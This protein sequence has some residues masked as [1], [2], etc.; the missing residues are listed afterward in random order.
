MVGEKGDEGPPGPPGPKG[1]RGMPGEWGIKTTSCSKNTAL[2]GLIADYIF[3]N[4]LLLLQE[5]FLNSHLIA[6]LKFILRL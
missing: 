4:V 2:K 3:S 6:E 1:Q 5:Y